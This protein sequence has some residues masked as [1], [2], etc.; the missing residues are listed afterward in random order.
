MKYTTLGRTNEEISAIGF[1]GMPLS[2]QGRP[3]EDAGRVR[4]VVLQEQ[5]R[6][7]V[8]LVNAEGASAVEHGY[9]FV[10]LLGG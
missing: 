10:R 5:P 7:S 2:I 6:V 8:W 9:Q 4:E 1:G 3:P